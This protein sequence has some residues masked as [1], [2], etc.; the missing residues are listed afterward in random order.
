LAQFNFYYQEM[1]PFILTIKTPVK[2]F[3]RGSAV[4]QTTRYLET[5]LLFYA[6][7]ANCNFFWKNDIPCCT[8]KV[9]RKIC[10]MCQLCETWKLP[11]ASWKRTRCVDHP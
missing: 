6:H 1:L 7:V 2:K 10:V 9:L 4:W 5:L 8:R 11:P 3:R